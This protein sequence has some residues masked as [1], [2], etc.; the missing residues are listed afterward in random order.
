MGQD[1]RL[2]AGQQV[3]ERTR[4]VGWSPKVN[5]WLAKPEEQQGQGAA[6][7]RRSL[8]PCWGC[9]SHFTLPAIPGES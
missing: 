1:S 3:V 9:S 5:Q 2:G 8:G 7:T 6:L 4:E